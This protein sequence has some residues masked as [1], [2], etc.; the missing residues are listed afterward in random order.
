MAASIPMPLITQKDTHI[1]IVSQLTT[2]NGDALELSTSF[3]SVDMAT[4]PSIRKSSPHHG[5]VIKVTQGVNA[6]V[7]QNKNSNTYENMVRRTISEKGGDPTEFVLGARP[8]GKR[9]PET[10]FVEHKGNYYLELLVMRGTK[11]KVTYYCDGKVIDKNEII[12]MAKS[13]DKHVTVQTVKL[14]NI[15]AIRANGNVYTPQLFPTN[16]INLP[17]AVIKNLL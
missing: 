13:S 16:L 17:T 10:P 6:M 4:V 5:R 2:T 9:I 11:P 3:V 14:C 7:A 8:W 15:T 12:G 1:M